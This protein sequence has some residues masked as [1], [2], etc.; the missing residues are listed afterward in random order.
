MQDLKPSDKVEALNLC[1]RERL[2]D[3][4]ERLF[5]QNG[6]AETPVRSI[7]AEA[8]VNIAAINY[9]FG[10]RDGL[11]QA[12]VARRL[13]P[14]DQKRKC[15]LDQIQSQESAPPTIEDLLHALV[16]PSIDLCFEHPYFARLLSQLRLHSNQTLWH[17]YRAKRHEH[18]R[19]F[20]EAFIA[21]LP[22]IETEE[23]EKRFD[24]LMGAIH[25]LWSQC[26]L[27]TSETP[28]K[29]LASFLTFYSAALHAPAPHVAA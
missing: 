1:A 28:P 11:F 21:A 17:D 23:V 5:A 26:P 29:V 3:T 22:E 15:L 6:I 2:M 14:F 24:Y 27:P 8:N 16:A 4:A 7:T 19:P 18:L 25:H 10:S 12:V 9:Y 20:R 13:E